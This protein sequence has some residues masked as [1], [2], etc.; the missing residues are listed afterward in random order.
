MHALNSAEMYCVRVEGQ[1]HFRCERLHA[2]IGTHADDARRRNRICIDE[3]A[4]DGVL[5]DA[6]EVRANVPRH[7][8]GLLRDLLYQLGQLKAYD[9]AD[10][11]ACKFGLD[12]LGDLP[13]L[14]SYRRCGNCLLAGGPPLDK[15]RSK[16]TLIGKQ[17]LACLVGAFRLAVRYGVD[18]CCDLR[19]GLVVGCSCL[20]QRHL[21]VPADGV[22]AFLSVH[23]E[24]VA[25]EAC[26]AWL[27]QQEE[28]AAV[29]QLVG[30]VLRLGVVDGSGA[31]RSGQAVGHGDWAASMVIPLIIPP[32]PATSIH[33]ALAVSCDLTGKTTYFSGN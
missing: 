32:C 9:R 10:L 20:R 28:A 16:Q 1:R 6:R 14:L 27:D 24:L 23:P 29:A 18:S 8:R 11:F 5:E 13:G 33:F 21:G 4:V 17:N 19:A 30:P 3:S 25:P 22:E 2:L 31:E 15:H 7:L 26:A 12:V